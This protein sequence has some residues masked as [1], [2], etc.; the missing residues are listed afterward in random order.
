[1]KQVETNELIGTTVSK[2]VRDYTFIEKIGEPITGGRMLVKRLFDLL[3]GF[4]GSIIS[5]P[6]VL[7]FAFIVKVTSSGPAFYRQERVGYMGSTFNVIK[8]RSMYQ[9]A[10]SKTGAVWAK[11]DDPRITTIGKFM[12]KTRIDELPQFWNVLKGDMSLVGPRPERPVLT[13]EFS[14]DIPEFPKRLRIIPGIT[15]YAQIN[16]GYDISPKDKCKLDNYYIE[17]YSLMFDIRILFGTIRIILTG[18]GAR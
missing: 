2:S 10:E 1:M 9:N 8:L 15:G 18:D 5:L 4:V 11:K 13:E 7:I 3:V 6:I 17:H 12:R 16:G 14:K